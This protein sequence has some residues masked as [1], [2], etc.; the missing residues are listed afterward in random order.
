MDLARD[1]G[2]GLEIDRGIAWIE[3][4]RP[5]RMNAL[6]PEGFQALAALAEEAEARNDVRVIVFAGVGGRAFSAG[7]DIKAVLAKGDIRFPTPMKGDSRNPFER[8]MEIN[9]PTIACLEGVC[10]GAGADLAM[11]CDLR[12]AADT[13]RFACS[14]AKVGMGAHFA[15]VVLPLLLPRPLALEL[16]YTGR[17][18]TLQE[19]TT[20]GFLNHVLPAGDVRT[21]VRALADTI[22]ANA[23]LTVRR[24]KEVST[25]SMGMPLAAALRLNVGPDPYNSQDRLEGMT[26]FVEKRAPN[27]RGH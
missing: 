17:E 20:H 25:K 4:N 19:G 22:A 9:K 27:F 15:S 5:E 6:A 1:H 8:V 2:V 23:P 14:E 18:M 7:I 26:A 3:I 11:A 10:M 16:L 21:A 13:L 12:L 24:C